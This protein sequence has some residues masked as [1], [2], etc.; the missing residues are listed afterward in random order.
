MMVVWSPAEVLTEYEDYIFATSAW[1][2]FRVSEF[3]II[4]NRDCSMAAVHI[5]AIF[6]RRLISAECSAT[7]FQGRPP[8]PAA[9][10]AK[11]SHSSPDIPAARE[12]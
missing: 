1:N 10:G 3:R 5:E 8:T 7:I 12:R 6:D 9:V 4:A 2:S 11:L